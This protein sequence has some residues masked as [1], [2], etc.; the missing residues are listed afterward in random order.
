VA[1][2]EWAQETTTAG[3]RTVP[4]RGGE[5][6]GKTQACSTPRRVVQFAVKLA[7]KFKLEC[8]RGPPALR[9]EF[10]MRSG[11]I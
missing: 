8:R 2:E 11:G 5:A 4:V 10:K 6:G 9:W 3:P 1:T 7:V